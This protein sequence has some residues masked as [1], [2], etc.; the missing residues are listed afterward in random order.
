MKSITDSLS[1]Q[2]L[3]A[4]LLPGAVTVLFLVFGW[5][6]IPSLD[7][8]PSES[9]KE[10][11]K[12]IFELIKTDWMSVFAFFGAAYFMGHVVYVLGSWLDSVYDKIKRRALQLKKEGDIGVKPVKNSLTD[13]LFPHLWDTHE[14]IGRV[15]KIKNAKIG[16]EFDGFEHQIIDTYQ[17]AFR[18]LMKEKPEMY[19]EAERYLATARFFRSMVFVWAFGAIIW[20]IKAEIAEKWCASLLFG[21]CIISF[22]TFLNRW[23][24]AH[25]VAFKNVIILEGRKNDFLPQK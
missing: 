12:I 22:F 1:L 25:H 11:N 3:L 4:V 20:L 21:L 7:M 5:Y 15:I 13:L 10:T 16:A 9:A 23:R 19:E 2:D 24:K 6:G 8:N 14:L 18:W 17:F